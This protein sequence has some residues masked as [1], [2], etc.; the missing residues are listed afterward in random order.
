MQ[1]LTDDVYKVKS[2]TDNDSIYTVNLTQ[3][4][5]TCFNWKRERVPCKHMWA[6]PNMWHRLPDFYKKSPFFSLDN[7]IV[8]SGP[9]N[10][11]MSFENLANSPEHDTTLKEL[12]QRGKNPR[13]EGKKCRELNKHIA[14]LTYVLEHKDLE[15][16][17]EGLKTLYTNFK[18]KV[19]KSS[20]IP[21]EKQSQVRPQKSTTA[22]KKNYAKLKQRKRCHPASGRVGVKAEQLRTGYHVNVDVQVNSL[23]CHFYNT[24]YSNSLYYSLKDG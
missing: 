13:A 3:P 23:T 8:S 21:L 2:Q 19:I 5:C 7:T 10:T 11:D 4:S 12:E 22:H 15:E 17:C 9:I 14:N 18:E 24:V 6:I 1:K 16:L 20:G